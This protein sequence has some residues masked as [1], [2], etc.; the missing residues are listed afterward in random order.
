MERTPTRV[1]IVVAKK[2]TKK[3][4]KTTAGSTPGNIRIAI[5]TH[6]SGGTGRSS[7]SSELA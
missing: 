2:A 7:P 1:F 3:V 6:A 4:T 5:G